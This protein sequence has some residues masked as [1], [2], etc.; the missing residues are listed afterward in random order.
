M[1]EVQSGIDAI[2]VAKTAGMRAVPE[3]A[4]AGVYRIECASSGQPGRRGREA[5]VRPPYCS[6]VT[7]TLLEHNGERA[8]QE[9][10]VVHHV[11]TDERAQ[12]TEC[13]AHVPR[14]VRFRRVPAPP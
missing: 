6:R 14:T 12:L 10:L 1:V 4:P 2:G 8:W 5:P 9:V 11:H 7:L 13:V 3:S